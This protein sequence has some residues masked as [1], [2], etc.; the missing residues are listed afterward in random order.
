MTGLVGQLATALLGACIGSFLNVVIYRVPRRTFLSGGRRS[1]CP[2]C[3][4]AIPW[5]LNLPVLS[6]AVLR[7]R[8]ACCKTRISVRYPL[9]EAAT[10]AAFWLLWTYPPSGLAWPADGGSALAAFALHATFVSILIACSFIDIDHRILPD[11]LTKPAI[12]IGCA[13]A[14]LVPGAYGQLD[15]PDLPP[16]LRSLAFSLAG[17]AA[18]FGLTKGIQLFAGMVL[19]KNAMGHGDV[20]FMAAMG[21][22]LGW[23]DV[24]LTFF[25]GCMY[26]AAGGLLHR[27]VTG[28]AYIWFGPFLAAGAVTMLFAGGQVRHFLFETWPEWQQEHAS[29]PAVVFTVALVS[30]VLLFLLIRRGRRA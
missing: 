16:S 27:M 7:G 15:L 24:T 3:G 26:G 11:V 8:S 25:L 1:A 10:A 2:R 21:A 29:S 20:K 23:Q 14:L 19:R 12:A 13:G 4:A 18:G 5:F 28:D 30:V 9:V 17:A 6:W 22:F